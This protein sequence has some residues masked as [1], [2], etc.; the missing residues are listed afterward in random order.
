MWV[1]DPQTAAELDAI[2]VSVD[3]GKPFGDERWQKSVTAALGLESSYR[4]AGR[5]KKGS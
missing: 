4:K 5:P 2:R 3:N 1:N